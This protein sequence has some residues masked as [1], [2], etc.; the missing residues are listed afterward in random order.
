[1]QRDLL[2]IRAEVAM[3]ATLGFAQINYFAGNK[4]GCFAWIAVAALAWV[5]ARLGGAG[6][7]TGKTMES[8]GG[9]QPS[10]VLGPLQHPPRKP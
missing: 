10:A 8:F 3:Y 4:F 9:Y 1:M 5:A 7:G 6:G 2:V